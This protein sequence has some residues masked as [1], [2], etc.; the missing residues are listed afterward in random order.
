[1]A[2]TANNPEP[3][4]RPGDQ[5]RT[6]P[7]AAAWVA[8]PLGSLNAAFSLLSLLLAGLAGWSLSRYLEEYTLPAAFLAVSYSVV[9]A[10]IASHRPRNPLGWIFLA[11]GF[12]QGFDPFAETY[13]KYVLVTNPGSS[14][15]D[16]PLMSWLSDY[17]WLPGL[18]LAITFVP[19]LFPDGGLP[20]RRWRAVAWLSTVPLAIFVVLQVYLWPYRGRIPPPKLSGLIGALS[21]QSGGLLGPLMLVCACACVSS[22][23]FRYRRAAGRERQQIKWFAYAAAVF[24]TANVVSEFLPFG[25]IIYL[26]L[27]PAA[28]LVPV[29][30][31]IAILRY[32]LYDID[33]IINRTLV[34][35]ALTAT[36]ALIYFGGVAT[37]E[38]IF[39]ALTGEEQQPQL[40]VVVSTLVIAALFMPLRRRIQSFIDR[41]FYRRK[42]NAV[43]TLEA[44]SAKLRDETDLDALSEDLVR[45]VSETIQPAH[46]S[47]WLHPDPAL[48]DNK[49][50]AA[51]RESG[52]DEE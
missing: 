51:I 5:G 20:S 15:P 19:L 40:A 41:R 22:L 9:G 30:V 2:L 38:A 49:K 1:M 3:N 34:Y 26:S 28:S 31:G 42:Y 27:L 21:D 43:K 48:K 44:F 32:R 39:H 35:G 14:L 52:R 23:M 6:R 33:V 46:V 4:A 45:V 13:A 8:V 18:S 10:L 7:R 16:G 25:P 24:L 12:F 50:R 36:L 37:T 11:V 17:T 47:L 29:A